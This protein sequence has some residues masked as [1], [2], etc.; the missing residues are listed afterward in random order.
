MLCE[1]YEIRRHLKTDGRRSPG[2]ISPNLW[3]PLSVRLQLQICQ[4]E[5][6]KYLTLKI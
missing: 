6:N 1:I 4:H 2:V 3:A 5:N